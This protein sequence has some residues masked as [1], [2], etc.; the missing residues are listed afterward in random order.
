MGKKRYVYRS[1]TRSDL[2][3]RSSIP[4]QAN[5]TEVDDTVDYIDCTDISLMAIKNLI[6]EPTFSTAAVCTDSGVNVWS[7]Y[8]PTVRTVNGSG[9]LVNSAPTVTD[10]YKLSYFAGYNDNATTP[11][12]INKNSNTEDFFTAPTTNFIFRCRIN[13]GEL[14]YD[15]IVSASTVTHVAFSVWDGGTWVDYAIKPIG[16]NAHGQDN[17]KDILD[18]DT[19]ADD[20]LVISTIDYSKT[21]TLKIWFL[22]SDAWEPTGT[23]KV[24]Q[25]TPL[26][27]WTHPVYIMSANHFY[28]NAPYEDGS[29]GSSTFTSGPWSVDTAG[30]DYTTGKFTVNYIRTSNYGTYN[31]AHATVFAELGYYANANPSSWTII[32]T[33]NES[34]IFFDGTFGVYPGYA[35]GP[36]SSGDNVIAYSGTLPYVN[37]NYGLRI[38]IKIDPSTV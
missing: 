26:D 3:T 27:D 2:K 33:Y 35:I 31:H 10:G 34:S 29:T 6:G 16:G 23:N 38:K 8:G 4:A 18:F 7:A 32:Q 24:C 13:I 17:G 5:I 28:M 25:L 37:G 14:T 15:D 9:Y 12:F 20:R 11:Y 21:F 22:S 30:F 36:V 1:Y 19:H